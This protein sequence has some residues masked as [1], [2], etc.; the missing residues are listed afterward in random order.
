MVDFGNKLKMLRNGR[1]FT[2]KQIADKL[3][4]TKSVISA[5]ETSTRYPSYDIL[6]KIS[7]ILGVTTDFLLGLEKNC[8]ID[9]SKLTDKQMEILHTIINE[10]TIYNEFNNTYK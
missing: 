1:H 5:Y 4:L 8:T 6:I 2:Q 7:S 3:G 10:F 9:I